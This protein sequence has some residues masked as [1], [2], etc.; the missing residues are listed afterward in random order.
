MNINPSSIVQKVLENSGKYV[1]SIG[2]TIISIGNP[3]KVAVGLYLIFGTLPFIAAFIFL[4]IQAINGQPN[5]EE[6]IKLGSTVIGESAI[7]FVTF[8]LGLCVDGKTMVNNRIAKDP[9]IMNSYLKSNNLKVIKY[10]DDQNKG[11]K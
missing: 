11:I 1:N 4:M 7:S 9:K 6:L 10:T 8:L 3:I 2:S 5:I